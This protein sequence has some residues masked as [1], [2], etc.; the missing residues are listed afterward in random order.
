MKLDPLPTKSEAVPTN[1][2]LGMSRREWLGNAAMAA[3][4]TFSMPS[5]RAGMPVA[6]DGS[7]LKIVRG[8]LEKLSPYAL[9]EL[10]HDSQ[11]QAERWAANM[12]ERFQDGKF[13]IEGCNN[14]PQAANFIAKCLDEF[15]TTFNA[16]GALH[17]HRNL[18]G[19]SDGL[20][21]GE[22]SESAATLRGVKSAFYAPMYQSNE[23]PANF[24]Q[25]IRDAGAP[26]VNTWEGFQK[27]GRNATIFA[28]T[29]AILVLAGGAYV[30]YQESL[31]QR[32]DARTI[33]HDRPGAL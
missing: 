1:D 11:W 18:E 7:E 26:L 30:R 25:Q 15:A 31:A 3:L 20:W 17:T 16:L 8:S 21:F 5:L 13:K 19:I 12:L 29:L 24:P 6:H 27:D 9:K 14:L 33:V 10:G 4:A 22:I 2:N 23:L 32:K 28:G